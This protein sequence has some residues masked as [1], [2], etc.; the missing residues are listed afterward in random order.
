MNH[1]TGRG[2]DLDCAGFRER[3]D[4]YRAGR[5]DGEA[6][7]ALAAHAADC[8]DCARR[9]G[10]RGRP[11][12]LVAAGF[13]GAFAASILTLIYTGL[14]VREAGSADERP[15]ATAPVSEDP[16]AMRPPSRGRDTA[17]EADARDDAAPQR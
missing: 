12:R 15:E 5:L 13:I 6:A 9:L 2:L 4:D 11:P 17:A 3:I 8:G 14:K 1:E 7:R 10:P 16:A